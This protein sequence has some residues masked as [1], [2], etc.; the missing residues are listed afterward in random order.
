MSMVMD[1]LWPI[2]DVSLQVEWGSTPTT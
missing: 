2:K 1:C